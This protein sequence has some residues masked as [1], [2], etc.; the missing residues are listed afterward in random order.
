MKLVKCGKTAVAGLCILAMMPDAALA[1]S[2]VQ[3][4]VKRVRP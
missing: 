2:K 3:N 1:P 4:C